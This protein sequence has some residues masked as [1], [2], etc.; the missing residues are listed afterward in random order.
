[1]PANGV[2]MEAEPEGERLRIESAPRHAQLLDNTATALVC[3]RA[4][5]MCRLW[6]DFNDVHFS[7]DHR[8]IG[9]RA[10]RRIR[11]FTYCYCGFAPRPPPSI[12]PMI[13]VKTT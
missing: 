8:M 4:V 1:M 10:G 12:H 9:H 11:E 2:R 5:E 6:C 7:H 13:I 3:Q